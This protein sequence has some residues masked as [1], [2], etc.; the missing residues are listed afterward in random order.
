[1]PP[2]PRKLLFDVQQAV[3]SVATFTRG[4]TF[5]DCE[6]DAMLRSAVERQLEIGGEPLNQLARVDQA[7]AASVGDY[8]RII[9][10]RNLLIHDYAAVDDRVVWDIVLADVP[11][12]V[13]RGQPAAGRV[14]AAQEVSFP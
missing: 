12:T 14:S 2:E 13:R 8:R 6:S 11:P 7:A 1:M 9:S 3:R 10:F 5:Q 4:K